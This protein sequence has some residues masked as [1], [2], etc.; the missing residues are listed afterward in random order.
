[1][2][3]Q[4]AVVEVCSVS[5]GEAS[6]VNDFS[7]SDGLLSPGRGESGDMPTGMRIVEAEIE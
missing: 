3:T 4:K 7:L 2:A 6:V 5:S 1:L